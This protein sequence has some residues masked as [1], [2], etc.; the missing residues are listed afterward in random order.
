MQVTLN[1]E[2]PHDW[3]LLLPLLERLGIGITTTSSP[4]VKQ[5]K[6]LSAKE[7]AHHKAIIE[8]GGDAQQALL[9]CNEIAEQVGLSNMTLEEINIEINEVRSSKDLEKFRGKVLFPK[10]LALAN[11]L[12]EKATL[13]IFE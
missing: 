11:K 12:L 8:K 4:V 3:T 1:I 2:N 5:R 13:P 9:A 10:K 6:R 7:L